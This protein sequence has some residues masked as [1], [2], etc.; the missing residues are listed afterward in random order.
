MNFC[1]D[2]RFVPAHGESSAT[3][4]LMNEAPGAL[5]AE[6]GIPSFGA[7]GGNI[8]RAFRKAGIRWANIS[9]AFVWP[10]KMPTSI[11][12]LERHSSKA[13]FLHERAQHMSCTNAYSYWPKS[14]TDASDFLPPKKSDVLSATNLLRIRREVHPNHAVLLIC[15]KYAYLACSGVP[16]S[17]PLERECT[18][19]SSEELTTINKRLQSE[20]KIGLYMGHTRR[21]T[22]HLERTT[23]ALISMANDAAWILE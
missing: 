12:S 14:G 20:F 13:E 16:I 8:Y 4:F 15:G 22:L 21:W 3:V 5:E 7:Q 6:S 19:L 10:Q 23:A 18:P 17:Y 11:R 9:T 1:Y 2:S